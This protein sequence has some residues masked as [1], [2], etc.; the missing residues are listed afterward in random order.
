ML[1]QKFI[2]F[3][4]LMMTLFAL[5][6][7]PASGQG[8]V[9]KLVTDKPVIES[10]AQFMTVSGA[11]LSSSDLDAFIDEQMSELEMP[12]LAIAIIN[13]G[14]IVYNR[15]LGVKNLDTKA[16]VDQNTLFE[17][18]SMSKP[19]LAYLAMRMVDK[20]VLDLDKPLY[21]YLPNY[22][23]D[24]DERY[25]KITARM[26]LTHVTGMP[27]WRYENKGQYL[28][29]R[30]DPGAEFSYS[31]EGFEYLGN[32]VA[33]L[34]GGTRKDLEDM[35]QREVF[36]PMGGEDAY[37]MQN[38]L[39][40]AHKANGHF[41]GIVNNIYK[42]Q[43]PSMAGGLQ[44]SAVTYAAFIIGLMNEV[45]LKEA[46][47]DELFSRQVTL[48]DN[49]V[50]K[51]S[52]EQDAW[53]LGFS[54]S[55]SPYGEIYGHGGNNGDFQS[56][57]EFS[58]STRTGYVFLTNCNQG[59]RFNQRL[60]PFL[61]TGQR[62]ATELEKQYEVIDRQLKPYQ[63]EQFDGVE[64]NAFPDDG[65]AWIRGQDF[66]EGTIELDIKGANEPGA[67]FVGVAFHG[68]DPENFEGVYFRPFNFV[69][70]TPAGRSHMVQ[71]HHPPDDIWSTLREAHPEKYEA[72]IPNPPDPDSWFH[73]RIEV[74]GKMISVYVDDKP[75]PVLEV[76]SLSDRTSG[77]I[78]LWVGMNSSGRFA[79]IRVSE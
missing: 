62:Y 46:T 24:Y 75:E 51:T 8:Q 1:K 63:D 57:F 21:Q 41:N 13:D 27:N 4:S 37:Y 3:A 40:D 73:A 44:T 25:R 31:G 15:T 60:K 22:D 14:K 9:V 30:F 35:I 48:P 38:D 71:Y 29:L 53:A 54:I 28:N 56:S 19:I 39:I 59:E 79:N 50:F 33:H 12:G 20:G 42:P 10:P 5:V 26:V 17:A 43:L 70:D 16:T 52:Y 36:G 47:Y 23:L 7:I 2:R 55:D 68:E 72:E 65:L 34:S 49:H 18:A 32:V 11:T 78:G 58:P 66:T 77:K 76:E 67:S 61:R 6:I 74:K 69:A 64:M 45:G